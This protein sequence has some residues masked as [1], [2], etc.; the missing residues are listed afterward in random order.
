MVK[1]YLSFHNS[2]SFALIRYFFNVNCKAILWVIHPLFFWPNF[3]LGGLSLLG[4][5]IFHLPN[6]T[7]VFTTLTHTHTHKHLFPDGSTLVL[8]HF[9]LWCNDQWWGT[10]LRSRIGLVEPI[11]IWWNEISFYRA[12]HIPRSAFY[13]NFTSSKKLWI[14]EVGGILR[15][16]SPIRH[17]KKL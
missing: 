5:L 9:H 7:N 14:L 2:S 6:P 8:C 1:L 17:N 15:K 4:F 13:S 3:F 10:R 11:T 16:L 12:W